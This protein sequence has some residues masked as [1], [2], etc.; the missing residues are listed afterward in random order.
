MRACFKKD[1]AKLVGLA[2]DF[3]EVDKL[4]QRTFLQY[5]LSMM[6][7][8]ILYLAGAKEINRAKGSELKFV[9]D[10]SKVLDVDKLDKANKLINESSYF[11]ERN[12]SA[13][14]I[15]L[16]LSLQLSKAINP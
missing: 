6:R 3:H 14:M 5:S 16:D 7:E 13:K 2:D 11:L 12:G 15:F 4:S 1:Y 10:F 9:Q 8:V